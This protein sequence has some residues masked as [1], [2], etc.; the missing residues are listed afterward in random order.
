MKFHIEIYVD[1]EED[2][3]DFHAEGQTAFPVPSAGD[4]I[5][6]MWQEGARSHGP[7]DRYRVD[8]VDHLIWDEGYTLQVRCTYEPLT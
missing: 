3:V 8:R 4:I 5:Q 7:T 6:P 2:A 1:G